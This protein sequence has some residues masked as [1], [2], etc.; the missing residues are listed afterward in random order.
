MKKRWECHTNNLGQQVHEFLLK[1]VHSRLAHAALAL[2]VPEYD[3]II[4]FKPRC[5]S[6]AM[7]VNA[8]R[9]Q[10]GWYMPIDTCETGSDPNRGWLYVPHYLS[11]TQDRK[12]TRLN[13][14]H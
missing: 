9:R 14:S 4:A 6:W 11:Y 7:L 3:Y 12:S 10:V 5:Q 2:V 13:S 1:A 8:I